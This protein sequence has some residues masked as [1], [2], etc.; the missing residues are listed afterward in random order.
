MDRI[1]IVRLNNQLLG[2]R[3]R[4]CTSESDESVYICIFDE[5]VVNHVPCEPDV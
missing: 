3:E 2:K 5:H 1:G 4:S